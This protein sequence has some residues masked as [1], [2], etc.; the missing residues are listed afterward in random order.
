[1]YLQFVFV[2][3]GGELRLTNKLLIKCVCNWQQDFCVE[4]F[5]NPISGQLYL[6]G[7]VCM[8][9]ESKQIPAN[10]VYEGCLSGS[11]FQDM[12]HKLRLV[13]TICGLLSL[14][15]LFV[16]LFFYLTLPELRNFQGSIICVYILSIIFTT[17]ILIVIYNSKLKVNPDEV[18]VEFFVSVSEITCQ[19]LGYCLYFSGILMF[20]WMSVLCFDLFWTFVYCPVTLQNKKNHKRFVAYSAFGWGLPICLTLLVYLIDTFQVTILPIMLA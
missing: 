15:F 9:E 6:S 2:A 19:N 8:K 12:N 5:Y 14:L 11:D 7:F 1:M 13:L 10:S 20:C 18:D 16:T 3:L 17:V 4:H